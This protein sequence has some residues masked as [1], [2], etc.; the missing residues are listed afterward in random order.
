MV[1]LDMLKCC[2]DA[3]IWHLLVVASP[4]NIHQIEVI[5]LL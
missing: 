1:V 2:F 5:T 3:I 4:Q